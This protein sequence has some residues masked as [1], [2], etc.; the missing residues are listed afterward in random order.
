MKRSFY[1]LLGV[2]LTGMGMFTACEETTES[3]PYANWRVRNERYL[4]SIADVAQTNSTGE[5]KIIR[6]YTQ[7]YDNGGSSSSMLPSQGET[8]DYIYVKVIQDAQA[9]AQQELA[10]MGEDPTPQCRGVLFTDSVYVHYKGSLINGT[11]FH[12]TF[13]S[14]LDYETATPIKFYVGETGLRNGFATALQAMYEGDHRLPDWQY[15]GDR[16]EVYIPSELAYG[17][18]DNGDIPGYSVLIFDIALC[19]VWG[20]DETGPTWN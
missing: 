18:S 12:G 17:T 20:I 4:D 9:L 6:A 10:Q 5:W 7:D 15:K 13:T 11:V 2:L 14:K 19:N 3:D 1:L 8:T 16:W